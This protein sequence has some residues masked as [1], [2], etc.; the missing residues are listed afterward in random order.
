MGEA[1]ER[2]IG[3]VTPTFS[4][5]SGWKTRPYQGQRLGGKF[6][7]LGPRV[8]FISLFTP[9]LS[10]MVQFKLFYW[11]VFRYLYIPAALD[12]QGDRTKSKP[13]LKG[14][15]GLGWQLVG[16]GGPR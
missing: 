14:R 3:F 6:V 11:V 10:H 16:G 13:L 7:H 15:L 1:R 9:F 12:V 8:G 4:I 2:S 5:V